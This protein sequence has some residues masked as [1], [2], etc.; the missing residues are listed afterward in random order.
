MVKQKL[1]LLITILVFFSCNASIENSDNE[2]SNKNSVDVL[3]RK[4]EKF[5]ESK[6]FDK[7]ILLFD[8]ILVD[9]TY[10]VIY[11]R[12]GYSYSQLRHS[13]QAIQDF[14][15]TI[16]LNYRVEDSYFNIACLLN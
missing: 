15:K 12:R 5:Y 11:F 14:L 1:I 7:A 3:Y 10:D 8:S 9:T 2:V 13:E 16:Q 6:Q 4:S